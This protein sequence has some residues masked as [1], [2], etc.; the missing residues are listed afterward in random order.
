VSTQKVGGGEVEVEE[1]ED[2]FE[3]GV[4]LERSERVAKEGGVD[5]VGRGGEGGEDVRVGKEGGFEGV[6]G[7]WAW[8]RLDR[9]RDCHV[10]ILMF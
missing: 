3:D 1:V 5:R 9:G 2:C 8:G 6:V 10:S 7:G 4:D